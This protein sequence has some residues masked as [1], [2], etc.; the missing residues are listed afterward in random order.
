M[1]DSLFVE[2]MSRAIS[3]YR[4]ILKKYLTPA[5]RAAKMAELRLKDPTIYDD[6]PA[7]YQVVKDILADIEK[8][9]RVPNEGYYSYYGIVRFS[10]FLREYIDNYLVE[11]EFVIHK[12]QKAS[13]LLL[14]AIQLLALP[15]EQLDNGVVDQVISLHTLIIELAS[16][17][18][19]SIYNNTLGRLSEKNKGLY[20]K[21]TDDFRARLGETLAQ[22]A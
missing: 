9:I 3:D 2:T 18:Q 8:N 16:K 7:L 19:L 21:I 6:E 5:Q 22:A 13:N 17:E 20:R 15:P 14:K 4:Q 1:L 11:G 12:A 10:K